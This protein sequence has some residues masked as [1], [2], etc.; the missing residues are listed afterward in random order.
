MISRSAASAALMP[1]DLLSC[2]HCL[3]DLVALGG[4]GEASVLE[5]ER[6]AVHYPVWLG[7][8]DF[9]DGQSRAAYPDE[10][11]ILP[12]LAERYDRCNSS[13]LLSTVLD[14]TDGASDYQRERLRECSLHESEARAA[15]RRAMIDHLL[16]RSGRTPDYSAILEIGCGVGGT[17][18]KLAAKGRAFGIDTNLL[19][20]VIARKR[21]EELGLDVTFACAAPEA[22]PLESGAFS[23]VNLMHAY[24]HFSDQA[25]GLREVYRVLAPGGA[26]SF[27]VPN[28]LSLWIEPHTRLWGIGFLPRRLT[29]LRR[30]RNRSLWGLDSAVRREFGLN[31]DVHTMLVRYDVDGCDA[32]RPL[33]SAARVLHWI[34]RTPAVGRLVRAL[35]PGVE[36]IGWKQEAAEPLRVVV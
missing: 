26:S 30:V 32:G 20:L 12:A 21:A 33:D 22:L 23:L 34:E 25:R 14:F 27:N 7:I 6:C 10:D 18:F 2:P 36:V 35:Q 3:G 5:C 4:A 24:E 8:P 28:R 1:R 9:R 19:H 17:L 15:R 16:R 31:Y 11:R 29:A 13:E